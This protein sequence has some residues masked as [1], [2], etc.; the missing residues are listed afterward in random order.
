MTPARQLI[1]SAP[2]SRLQIRVLIVCMLA[3]MAEGYD[4]LSMSLAV[5]PLAD[6]WGLTGAQTGILLA[7]G[8]VGMIFGAIVLAPL[9]DRFGRRS[10]LILSL[11]IIAVFLGLS[12][13]ATD[14][15]QLSAFRLLAG[16]GMGGMLPI[17]TITVG[18]FAPVR[19]RAAAIG[20]LSVGLPLGSAVGGAG[21][22]L[23]MS[24]TGW[25]RAF[26]LGAVLTAL[27]CM[28]VIATVPETPDYLAAK[29][30]DSARR[31][32]EDILARMGIDTHSAALS[33]EFTNT[34]TAEQFPTPAGFAIRSWQMVVVVLIFLLVV[35]TYY[36]SSM[37]LPKLLVLA[38]MSTD[39]GFGGVLLLSLGAATAGLVVA[40]LSSRFSL[41]GL[42]V[43]FA[44]LSAILL[45]VFS[46]VSSN[47]MYA[48]VVA[49]VLGLCQ[50]A[51]N[52]AVY[53]LVP[54]LFGAE[55]R[56]AAMGLGI[57]I[58]R[59]GPILMPLGIGM[60]IDRSWHPESIF[61]LMIVPTLL[62]AALVYFL[63]RNQRAEESRLTAPVS[64]RIPDTMEASA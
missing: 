21:A 47:L 42:T 50:C 56:S 58:S 10:Q 19:R 15:T 44:I 34:N 54:A 27:V 16:V 12:A 8:P 11:S 6:I 46:L 61:Q 22:A 60:L 52:V 49:P 36:F 14:M 38:G 48:L 29:G 25:Q 43:T 53:A 59:I 45:A 2:I 13:L 55:N 3:N 1:D 40:V 20:I 4:L 17:L 30:T 5:V 41:F 24:D 18:E 39:G 33:A 23:L 64:A 37:W 57:G 9:S 32:L 28:L 31:R 26:V 63:W 35:S 7:M 62:S 51:T